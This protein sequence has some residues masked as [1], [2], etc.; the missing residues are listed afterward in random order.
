MEESFRLMHDGELKLVIG[1]KFALKDAAEAH[2]FIESRQ[3]TGKLVLI[4]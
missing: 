3:S 2:R 1:K 4:P